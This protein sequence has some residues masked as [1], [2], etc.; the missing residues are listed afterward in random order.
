M[1]AISRDLIQP[2]AVPFL[3]MGSLEEDRMQH[4]KDKDS[5]S[6]GYKKRQIGQRPTTISQTMYR[7][8]LDARAHALT[9]AARYIDTVSHD[10]AVTKAPEHIP[11]TIILNEA[12]TT[13]AD[14]GRPSSVWRQKP[15]FILLCESKDKVKRV[16]RA[17]Q[18]VFGNDQTPR[19]NYDVTVLLKG[20]DEEYILPSVTKFCDKIKDDRMLESKRPLTLDEVQ[21]NMNATSYA[22]IPMSANTSD[23]RLNNIQS[24]Y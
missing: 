7:V 23:I 24:N 11:L 14:G 22:S 3:A 20:K 9:H 6:S 2:E 10:I 13:S 8:A 18:D 16:M 1:I 21:G 4:L 12:A 17:F 15:E 5:V 19:E